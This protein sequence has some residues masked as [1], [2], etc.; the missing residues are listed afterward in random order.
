MSGSREKDLGLYA[1]LSLLVL[2][3]WDSLSL[4]ARIEEP[5]V[6]MHLYTCICHFVLSTLIILSF[7][8]SLKKK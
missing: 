7:S 5:N 4:G 1:L 8:F 2:V 6:M 3:S